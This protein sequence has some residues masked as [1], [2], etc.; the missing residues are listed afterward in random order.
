MKELIVYFSRADENYAVGYIEKGN[1][2][3]I[4]EY[5]QE[6][7]NADM[8]KIEPKN[9]YPVDYQECIR[10]AKEEL[11]ENA[12]PEI[13]EYL[14]SIEEYD[15]IYL[16]YPNWWGDLPMCVYTFLDHYDFTG[17]TIKPFCTHEGSGLGS[18][19]SKLSHTL[20]GAKI[21]Q[22]LEVQGINVN[23]AKDKVA[24]WVK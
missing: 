12:R 10:V 23:D 14:D 19:V 3:V 20:M 8:F 13:K 1:T 4:A 18:T 11:E 17:K 15:T 6:F 16:G 5:I 9:S 22:G 21:E 7:I 24:S 2:E